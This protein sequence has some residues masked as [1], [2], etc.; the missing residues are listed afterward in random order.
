[1]HGTDARRSQVQNFTM[2][3]PAY[4]NI[5]FY[6][7]ALFGCKKGVNVDAD[8]LFGCQKRVNVDVDA[9]FRCEKCINVDVDALF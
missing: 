7:E 3:C 8:A 2:R 1:M 5:R 4:E 9:L 6:V